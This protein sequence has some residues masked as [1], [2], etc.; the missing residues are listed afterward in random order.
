MLL[1]LGMLW[2]M[3]Y[4]LT[5]LALNTVPPIT[6]VAGRVSLAAI[7][8]WMVV[9]VRRKTVGGWRGLAGAVFFQG[10]VGCAVPYTFIAFGQQSVDSA[11]AAILNSTTPLFVCLINVAWL[12]RDRPSPGQWAGVA[13]GLVGVVTIAGASA[14]FGVGQT[15]VG[16]LAITVG[17]FSSA[18]SVIYGRRFSRIAPEVT[19][20]G[21]LT[22]ATILLVPLCFIVETPLDATPSV[23]SIVALMI[24]GVFSTALGFVLYFRLI[25]TFGSARVASVSYLKP[26]FGVLIGWLFM[27]EPA[28]WTAVGGLVAVMAG[29]ALMNRL[30]ERI[31]DSAPNAA[32]IGAR[33][34]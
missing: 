34:A 25:A 26:C 1:L 10:L 11:L 5:K 7:V 22:S 17:T 21:A 27:A 24:N 18:I 14:L 3:P 29:V 31:T 13:L 32:V 6:M 2:G 12:R 15:I 19:A 16:Q 4:A 30:S 9:L 28:T 33:R 23:M 20:A 8:L